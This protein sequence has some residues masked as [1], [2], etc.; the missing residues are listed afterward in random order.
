MYDSCCLSTLKCFCALFWDYF[1]CQKTFAV[2]VICF[3]FVSQCLIPFAIKWAVTK[4]AIII[5]QCS[6]ETWNWSIGL[7][8][9][10]QLLL[11]FVCITPIAQLLM[12]RAGLL[13][14]NW[15]QGSTYCTR[16]LWGCMCVKWMLL[17]PH[18]NGRFIWCFLVAV[19]S[20][21]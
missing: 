20:S 5:P 3:C 9:F 10:L 14:P 1:S 2:R 17:T 4:A 7:D 16:K 19:H 12:K 18:Q 11:L 13:N 8:G 21:R 15:W 6:A